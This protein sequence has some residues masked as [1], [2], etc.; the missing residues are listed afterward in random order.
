MK[1]PAILLIIYAI[2]FIWSAINPV[3]RAVWIV[4]ALTSLVPVV[5]LIILYFKKIRLSSLAYILMAVLPIMHVIGAHYTFAEVP[6]DWFNNL[7]DS[8]RNHYDR[9]AHMTVGFYAFGIVELMRIKKV[10][11]KTWFLIT[12]ALFAIISLAA[13]YELFEWQYAV[14]A[15]PDAGLAV[16]GSQGDIWDAQK[17]MFMDTLGAVI[18]LTIYWI[19]EKFGKLYK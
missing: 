8:D 1:T 18:A 6:F 7:L 15:D 12:Y 3:D 16:L 9:V 11:E 13:V 10:S 19:R 14:L 2:V 4:E 17:D 5:I